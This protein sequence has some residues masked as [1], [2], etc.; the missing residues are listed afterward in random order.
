MRSR[1]VAASAPTPPWAPACSEHSNSKTCSDAGTVSFKDREWRCTCDAGYTGAS[2]SSCDDRTHLRFN[3]VCK[4]QVPACEPGAC[5]SEQGE[6]CTLC[7]PG[8]YTTGDE[9]RARFEC[10]NEC[11]DFQTSNL[12]AKNVD[13]CFFAFQELSSAAGMKGICSGV[14]VDG[15][16]VT[17]IGSADGCRAFAARQ[18]TD[19]KRL[20]FEESNPECT[21]LDPPKCRREASKGSCTDGT[22]VE[23]TNRAGEK[24]VHAVADVCRQACGTC[25]EPLAGCIVEGNL[26]ASSGAGPYTVRYFDPED[27]GKELY[28]AGEYTPVCAAFLCEFED[29]RVGL[30]A[31]MDEQGTWEDPVCVPSADAYCRFEREEG[32]VSFVFFLIGFGILVVATAVAH[33]FACRG[34][35]TPDGDGPVK[36]K[37]NSKWYLCGASW[38]TTL[39]GAQLG[40]WYWV[41]VGVDLRLGDMI[42]DWGQYYINLGTP[43]TENAFHFKYEITTD[44]YPFTRNFKKSV[45]L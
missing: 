2:C 21:D 42:T 38:D 30:N 8:R 7:P 1:T 34:A 26:N 25:G 6:L 27:R 9:P 35:L 13:D 24:E 4:A 37:H 44:I 29:F 20:V 19:G 43:G 40:T 15:T 45:A 11:P 41:V 18:R 16:D 10:E 28:E 17:R 5:Y 3:G 32:D 12:G 36:P 14:G 33:V 31:I 23:M 22:K 39:L